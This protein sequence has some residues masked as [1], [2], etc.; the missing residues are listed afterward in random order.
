[1]FQVYQAVTS[2]AENRATIMA[3]SQ[4]V[5]SALTAPPPAAA[6]PNAQPAVDLQSAMAQLQASLSIAGDAGLRP[7]SRQ[8]FLSWWKTR[9][10][11][12]GFWILLGWLIMTM[13][14]SVGAPFWED[15]LES[16]FGIKSLIRKNSQQANVEQKSGEGNP[17][18]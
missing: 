3:A 15:A 2:S 16:L 13:L 4:R 8:D 9:D 10:L 6:Q 5:E 11:P 17:K 7:L 18:S 1:V 14:L 12:S